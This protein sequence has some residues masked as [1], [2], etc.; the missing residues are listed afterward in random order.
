MCVPASWLS[1]WTKPKTQISCLRPLMC[2]CNISLYQFV[3][4][5]LILYNNII[6]YKFVYTC[7]LSVALLC[8]ALHYDVGSTYCNM[9]VI[10]VCLMQARRER[11]GQTAHASSPDQWP[12]RRAACDS[13]SRCP[14]RACQCQTRLAAPAADLQIIRHFAFAASVRSHPHSMRALRK[15]CCWWIWVSSVLP[16]S[17]GRPGR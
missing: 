15:A 3:Y 7:T 9:S 12:S 2:L 17:P 13:T 11:A 6:L 10:K 8:S 14:A 4:T 1:P 16:V 5:Y